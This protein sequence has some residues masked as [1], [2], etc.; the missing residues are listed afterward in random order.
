MKVA[1]QFLVDIQLGSATITNLQIPVANVV[2][3]GLLGM[4]YL[5]VADAWIRA[6]E[7]QLHMNIGGRTTRYKHSSR[8]SRTHDKEYCEVHGK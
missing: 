3:D 4:D 8:H 2:G 6:K 7:G 5:R 1:R